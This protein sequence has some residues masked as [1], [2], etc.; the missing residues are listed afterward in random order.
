MTAP[1]QSLILCLLLSWFCYNFQSAHSFVFQRIASRGKIGNVSPGIILR[2][3]ADPEDE[4]EDP[5]IESDEEDVDPVEEFLAMEE[6]SRRVNRRLML[7][8][9]IISSIGSSI[10]FLAY[11]FVILSF[12][13][14]I[15]GYAII[16]D[17]DMI[18]IGTLEERDFQMEIA[19]SMK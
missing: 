15:A 10:Q 9:T 3:Q 8:R 6:A 4:R 17:D 1:K 7:P 14:N 19:K 18:R 11:G 13:L 5:K 2:A 16:N 12:A